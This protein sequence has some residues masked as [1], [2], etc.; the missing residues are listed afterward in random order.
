MLSYE[1][2]LC[3]KPYI[4]L[5][6]LISLISNSQHDISSNKDFELNFFLGIY[7]KKFFFCGMPKTKAHTY[8]LHLSLMNF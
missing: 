5:R 1:L 4:E 8:M 2:L 7:T 6:F 3:S